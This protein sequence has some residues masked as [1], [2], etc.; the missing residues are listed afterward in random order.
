MRVHACPSRLR[1]YVGVAAVLLGAL[2]AS[3]ATSAGHDPAARGLDL[4][5][6]GSTDVPSGGSLSLQ[7]EAIGFPDVVTPRPLAGASI[8][9]TWD[10]RSVPLGTK[11]TPVVAVAD[12]DGLAHLDVPVPKAAK[13]PKLLLAV[14]HGSHERVRELDVKVI[15]PL[16]LQLFL[17]D[18]KVVPGSSVLAW[19]L[20]RSRTTGLPLAGSPVVYE[21][22][23]GSLVRSS[24]RM[25][26]DSSGI[27]SAR[28]PIPRGEVP[29]WLLL[30]RSLQAD[31]TSEAVAASLAPRDE[32]PGMPTLAV[33]WEEL[34]IAAGERG[35]FTVL[36]HDGSGEP[37]AASPL[38]YLVLA[39]GQE[40]P[41]DPTQWESLSTQATT[42]AS[43]SFEG[44]MDAPTT[45]P[46][47]GLDMRVV[48][49]TVVYGHALEGVA[50]TSVAS[51][52]ARVRSPLEIQLVAEASALLPGIEQRLVLRVTDDKRSV[53]GPF[54]VTADGLV[55]TVTTNAL[56]VAEYAWKVP[57]GV[58]AFRAKGACAADVAAEVRVRPLDPPGVERRLCL[59]V[60]RDAGAFVRLGSPTV[61]AGGALP[62][63]IVG[64][65]D[66]VYSVIARSPDGAQ[67]VSGWTTDGSLE[68]TV[69]K[70]AK[71]L[72][73]VS[74][75]SPG[76]SKAA[77]TALGASVLVLPERLAKL[78][79]KTP[80]GRLA[81]GGQVV[82]DADLTDGR[83]V[84]MTG[85]VSALLL[86]AKGGADPLDLAL[87]D[88]R[89][90]LVRDLNVEADH[91]ALLESADPSYEALRRLA[92][93]PHGGGRLAPVVDPGAKVQEAL[94]EAFK[95]VVRQLEGAINDAAGSRER[96][97]DVA[98]RGPRGWELN[99]EIEALVRDQIAGDVETPGGEPMTLDDVKR[100]DRQVDFEHAARRVARY[101]LLQA[102]VRIR[103]YV[104]DHRLD[105]DEPI[106]KD[107]NA[108]LRRLRGDEEAPD[109][110][111]LDPW[112]GT[113][114]FV[115]D[116]AP[117]VA[118]LGSVPGW[119]LRSPGPDGLFGTPDDVRDPFERVLRSGTPY[120]KAVQEDALVDAKWDV[121]IA[122]STVEHWQ[123]LF[124][125]LTGHVWGDSIGDSFGS[126]GLGMSGV[127]N[128]GG[129]RGQGFGLGRVTSALSPYTHWIAPV[130]TDARGHVRLTVALGPIETTWKVW[131]VAVPDRG[132]AATTSVDVPVTLPISAT[133]E[134]GSVWT[135][136]DEGNV[137]VTVRNRTDSAVRAKVDADPQAGVV[138]SAAKL[139]TETTMVPARGTSTVRFALRALG[140]GVARLAVSVHTPAYD[141]RVVH[142]WDVRP[143]GEPLDVSRAV[144]VTSESELALPLDRA[145]VRPTGPMR[146]VLER[147]FAPVLTSTLDAVDP[148]RLRTADGYADA[149]EVAGRIHDWSL[150]RRGPDDALTQ[151][152]NEIRVRASA[153]LSTSAAR[154]AAFRA[155]PW[156][157]PSAQK[158]LVPQAYCPEAQGSL[159][160]RAEALFSSPLPASGAGLPCWD[161]HVA[162]TMHALAETPDPVATALAVLALADRPDRQIESRALTARLR[163]LVM[164]RPTGH[165][166]LPPPDDAD[167]S[168]RTIVLAALLRTSDVAPPP[169]ASA[170]TLASWLAVQRDA[171]GG[172]GT[173]LATRIAVR[174]LLAMSDVSAGDASVTVLTDGG[175]SVS[176]RVA[177]NE[178]VTLALGADVK[179]V[180]V[181]SDVPGVLAR[182][183]RPVLR[184]WTSPPSQTASPL[185][186]EVVWPAHPTAGSS[187]L[188]N[189]GVRHQL[190]QAAVVEIRIPLPP[191]A[192]MSEPA[193][194]VR[195]VAGTLIARAGVSPSSV[196]TALT[197]PIR[198]GL[199]GHFTAPEAYAFLADSEAKRAH[200]P[201]QPIDVK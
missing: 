22:M 146:L 157:E 53:T 106:Y 80:S 61:R 111:L 197:I 39:Q 46:P 89:T 154:V 73:T 176:A 97:Q 177:S 71:G 180:R 62:I 179:S 122:D 17:S 52:A 81:P 119:S 74:A 169:A 76:A 54:A 173:S 182:L 83:G 59:R 21:L 196:P 41:T 160:S 128:G 103:G 8:E 49:R 28:I 127:G 156:L 150:V 115:R 193:E 190:A 149:V 82:L 134:A 9:A 188:L 96:V 166:T 66:R 26:T 185:S 19:A 13:E 100:V 58:G 198:F 94:A 161:A 67:S 191:G 16:V 104:K 141:D 107:P 105:R 130:R 195:Q 77:S 51:K 79:A 35:H 63:T 109:Q 142:Q 186:L 155:W 95:Q 34:G 163:A 162:S 60:A 132:F 123:T 117:R 172:F 3:D 93:A 178:S 57:K 120:A 70:D 139:A 33:R 87:F 44:V 200:S 118:F 7:V 129:G 37:V 131:L 27:A 187:G 99:P 116:G 5:I 12:A 108:I 36:L 55:A 29:A 189:I 124:R 18:Q 135:E 143:A 138:L 171:T 30:V 168:S 152:A 184:S 144:W 125:E 65:R 31:A 159:R 102:L 110:S 167:R 145:S 69:P 86:D 194:G 98:R 78:S 153:R 158:G 140:P 133:V 174:A 42:D 92:L 181:R 201:S 75:T 165:V 101:R 43:G 91:D 192:R 32:T 50:G 72:W 4:F 85:T 40:A 164:P 137:I 183:V 121:E 11:V 48:V 1:K 24:L 151:R 2:L 20:V 15:A 199:S 47:K 147:G 112:G 148:D 90:E 114:R 170:S 6:H 84:P 175:S 38:R 88:T 56:G 23:D 126:G 64:E 14:R 136:G 25:K 68:L 10:P 113:M 45:V